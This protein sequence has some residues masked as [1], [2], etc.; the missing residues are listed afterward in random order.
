MELMA[1]GVMLVLCVRTFRRLFL[2]R[3]EG[4]GIGI[5]RIIIFVSEFMFFVV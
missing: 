5:R 2:P 3:R 4:W 1:S